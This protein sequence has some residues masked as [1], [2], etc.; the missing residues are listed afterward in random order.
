M[1]TYFP[2]KVGDVLTTIKAMPNSQYWNDHIVRAV[3]IGEHFIVTYV[4][5]DLQYSQR[6]NLVHMSGIKACVSL[7]WIYDQLRPFDANT[8]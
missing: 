6:V 5:Q 4:G 1:M 8:A 7:G 2:V 3:D